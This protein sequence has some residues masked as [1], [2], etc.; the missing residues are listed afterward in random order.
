MASCKIGMEESKG[1]VHR[2]KITIS[3][4]LQRLKQYP[5][6]GPSADHT[7]RSALSQLVHNVHGTYRDFLC[8]ERVYERAYARRDQNK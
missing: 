7:S 1:E 6:Y 4:P 3:P 8:R 2:E 5:L